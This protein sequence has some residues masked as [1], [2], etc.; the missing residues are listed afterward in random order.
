MNPTTQ[1]V[2]SRLQ[3]LANPANVAGMARY[4]INPDHTLGI[5]IPVLRQIA[6]ETG[7]DQALAVELWDTGIHE[8]RLLAGFIADPRQMTEA[9]LDRWVQ[10]FNSWDICDQTCGLFALT[11]FAYA[12]AFEW[13]S[14]ADTFIKRAG[15]VLMATLAVHDKRA[16]D[17]HLAQ[18]LPVIAR[19]ASDERNFVKKA[20]NWA[21]RQIGKRSLSLN[22]LAIATALQIQQQDSKAA[23]W[24]AS[25]ALRELTSEAVQARLETRARQTT[26]P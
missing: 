24:V 18:F 13:S 19:A 23:R 1:A 25:D 6:K 10:D 26:T 16:S 9:L 15:F 5:S 3:L 21:L 8:A 4:G 12:K 20:V 14:H 2:L 17:D 11:P 22:E 7:R